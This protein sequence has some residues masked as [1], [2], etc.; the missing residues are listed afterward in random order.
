MKFPARFVCQA[1]KVV[2]IVDK[3]PKSW[4]REHVKKGARFQH[5]LDTGCEGALGP[6]TPRYK[7]P[8]KDGVDKDPEPV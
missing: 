6:Y 7:S 4:S 8:R 3:A 1:C 5:R 2:V